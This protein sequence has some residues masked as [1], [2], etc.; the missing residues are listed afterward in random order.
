MRRKIKT[1]KNKLAR[2]QMR[3]YRLLLSVFAL[4]II[5]ALGANAQIHSTDHYIITIGEFR[6]APGDTVWMPIYFKNYHLDTPVTVGDNQVIDEGDIGGFFVRFVYDSLDATGDPVDDLLSPIIDYVDY[7]EEDTIYVYEFRMVGRGKKALAV[8]KYPPY[9]TAYYHISPYHEPAS[10]TT[11]KIMAIRMTPIWDTSYT[12]PVI[13][14]YPE[15]SLVMEVPF[16]VNEDAEHGENTVIRLRDGPYR[17]NQFSSFDGL[18]YILPLK[19]DQYAWFVVDTAGANTRPEIALSPST[20]S[21]Y[22][23]PGQALPTITITGT[24]EVDNDTLC[25]TVEHNLSG[26]PTFSPS[27]SVCGEG[28]A[29]MTFNWTSSSADDGQTYTVTFT[30]DDYRLNGDATA[31]ITVTVGGGPVNN[32]PVVASITPNTFEIEQGESL[33]SINVSATDPDGDSLWLEAINMPGNATFVGNPSLYGRGS[34]AGIFDWTPTFADVGQFTINFRATD[35]IGLNDTKSIYVTVSE[36]PVDRLFSKS[37]YAAG[38]RPVGG[39]PGA[40]PVIF[41]IDLVSQ[42]TVYGVNFDMTYPGHVS[43]LDS[44]VVTDRTPEY[45]V[46]DNIGSY[47]DSVRVVTF[48]MN[49]EPIVGGTSTAI[50]NAYFSMDTAAQSG[51]YWIYFH[52]AWESVNPDPEFPSLSL[53]VDSGII[54]VD[55]LGDVNLD[56]HIDVADLV[57][58]VGYI[59]DNYSFTKRHF[60]TAD[61]VTDAVVNVVDL[62]GILNMI[63]GYPISGPS[64]APQEGGFA[65]LSVIHEDLIAGQTTKLSVQG[66]FPEDVA[67]IQIQ[68][69]YDPS[70]LVFDDPELAEASD[71][72][73][74]VYRDNWRGRIKILLYSEQPWKSETLIPAGLSNVVR[75]P[76]HII[77]NIEADDKSRIRITQAYLSN[78]GASEIPMKGE[79]VLLPTTFELHQNYPNPFNPTTRIDFDIG[80]SG[81]GEIQN[82]RLDVFNILGR[83]ITTLVNEPLSPG[84]HSVTWDATDYVGSKVATGIYLYRLEVG[85]EHQTKKMLLLK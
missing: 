13:E 85:D 75:L 52:D 20:T 49:N 4:S 28:T 40:T 21:Y 61:V 67:G 78:P 11:G 27:D 37:T 77:K 1:R 46:F 12:L 19:H 74:L 35:S 51:D 53:V 58:V 39:I 76:A 29:Q 2:Q 17:A 15:S 66:E 43:E 10:D 31:S 50:L 65:S 69:D 34:V 82:V 79:S 64:P 68:I 47:P 36:V 83:R 62:V 70:A 71:N 81:D 33:P 8:N 57:N 26:S 25:I 42:R 60:E 84:R 6:G 55:T 73:R 80:H 7:L 24:D 38:T 59:I 54:Q 14:D 63:F 56:Q 5:F 41:P 18:L 32:P 9:D 44:I 16:I 45:S 72:F 22:I 3:Y 48:G 30:A 23:S